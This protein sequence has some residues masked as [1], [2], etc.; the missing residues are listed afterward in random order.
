MVEIQVT[1]PVTLHARPAALIV[2]EAKKA[3][4]KI[5][6]GNEKRMVEATSLLGILSLGAGKGSVVTVQA[7]GEGA[8]G[9]ARTFADVIASLSE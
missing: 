2:T 5:K 3:A 1:L 4:G 8:A 9:A 6:V 7:E